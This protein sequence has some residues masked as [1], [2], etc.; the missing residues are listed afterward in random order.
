MLIVDAHQDIA[1]NAICF[2][3]DYQ[4]GAL[5]KRQLEAGSEVVRSAGV[6]TVGLPEALVGRVAVVFATVFTAPHT[7]KPAPWSAVMYRDA[8]EAYR[9]GMQQ[10]DY[11]HRLVD[12]SDRLRL[13]QAEADLDAVLATWRDGTSLHERQQGLVLLMENADPILEA[14]QFEAWY[15]RG[16]RIVGPAWQASRYSGGTGAPGPL[17]DEGHELLDVMWGF[18]AILD[19]SHMAE[20][21]FFQALDQYNGIVIA[22]H[23]NPRRFC[24]TDRHLSDEMILRLAERDGVMGV[25]F[26]NAFLRRGW[27]RADGKRSLT[28]TRIL[29]IID[30]VC[31]VT[32]SAAHV[33]IGTDF[34]G[35]FGAESIPYELDTVADLWQ[36][37]H[38]LNVR[39]FGE[40]DIDAILGGNMLRKLR[41]CLAGK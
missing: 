9:T 22:S 41:A 31:Q 24:E 28:L 17:T 4:V 3:R 10:V 38:A 33:G 12:Y 15:E 7:N 27:S 1:Y 36:L 21:A 18:N 34:D 20:Q 30:H 16:V 5:R 23:S 40:A 39:G 13:I 35:G 8:G 11:Y 25:N 2:G 14:K 19:V 29:D 37:R 26:Y 32:G 6:A